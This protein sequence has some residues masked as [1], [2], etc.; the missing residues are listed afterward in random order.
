V[1]VGSHAAQ[2]SCR[3]GGVILGA[4]TAEPPEPFD[5]G[6]LDV[7]SP[8]DAPWRIHQAWPGSE[9]VIVDH[10]GHGGDTMIGL[11]RRVVADLASVS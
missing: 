6:R 10:E 2:R 5:A 11:C 7:S 9:L 1:I 4:V 3:L 8:L